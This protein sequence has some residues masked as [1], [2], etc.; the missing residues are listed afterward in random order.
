M[1]KE[2]AVVNFGE[3]RVRNVLGKKSVVQP[4]VVVENDRYDNP[5]WTFSD[6]GWQG[7]G[8]NISVDMFDALRELLNDH[9]VVEHYESLRA[10]S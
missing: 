2:I 4:Q 10:K 8:V 7:T 9:R 5:L 6:N 1:S 3:R